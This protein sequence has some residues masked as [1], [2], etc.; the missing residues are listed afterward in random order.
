LRRIGPRDG[1]RDD[2]FRGE[3][4]FDDTPSF[5][6]Q[7]HLPILVP[8][9]VDGAGER[10]QAGEAARI[11]LET[12]EQLLRSSRST[13]SGWTKTARSPGGAGSNS[14]RPS[15]S[16]RN[17]RVGDAL[18]PIWTTRCAKSP[19]GPTSWTRR[20]ALLSSTVTCDVSPGTTTAGRPS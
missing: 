19:S 9:P 16:A 17:Q 12:P 11:D 6:A 7:H 3:A 2:A 18:S 8:R 10:A 5:D 1:C 14:N 13:P 4:C 20:R 15:E